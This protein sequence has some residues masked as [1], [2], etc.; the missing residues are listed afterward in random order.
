V[1]L[2]A[3]AWL[4]PVICGKYAVKT[5]EADERVVLLGMIDDVPGSSQSLKVNT[6]SRL[7]RL[8]HLPGEFFL[9]LNNGFGARQKIVAAI[10]C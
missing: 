2:V 6:E 5:R 3:R 8:E 9:S 7:A 10:H 1:H 4:C